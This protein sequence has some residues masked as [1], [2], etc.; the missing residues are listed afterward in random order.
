MCANTV[1]ITRDQLE[2]HLLME[3]DLRRGLLSVCKYNGGDTS[4]PP[5]E[6]NK[7]IG[8]IAADPKQTYHHDTL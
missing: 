3:G 7:E 6:K 1:V 8:R 4:E 2:R 5:A